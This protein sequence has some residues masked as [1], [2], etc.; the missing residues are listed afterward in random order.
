MLRKRNY[1]YCRSLVEWYRSLESMAGVRYYP[2]EFMRYNLIKHEGRLAFFIDEELHI[3]T[4]RG[5]FNPDT[6]ENHQ[7]CYDNVTGR[8]VKIAVEWPNWYV[9]YVE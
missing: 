1:C 6:L 7:R 9:W 8:E 4:A 3:I 5:D 2:A